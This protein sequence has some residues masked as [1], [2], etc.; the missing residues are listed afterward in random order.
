MLAVV[1]FVGL[2]VVVL[3]LHK[4]KT[5]LYTQYPQLVEP[6]QNPCSH[7]IGHLLMHHR[8]DPTLSAMWQSQ[9]HGIGDLGS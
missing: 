7:A 4:D 5:A 3:A 9:T 2:Q 8:S 1:L 6:P